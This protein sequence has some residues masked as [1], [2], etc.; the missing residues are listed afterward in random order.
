VIY[1]KSSDFAV[2]LQL[3]PDQEQVLEAY[4]P[5]VELGLVLVIQ[6][7]PLIEIADLVQKM[8]AIPA[9]RLG[10]QLA[11]A[12]TNNVQSLSL[13]TTTV[14][15]VAAAEWIYT[16][17]DATGGIPVN[18]TVSFFIL[19]VGERYVYITFSVPS[20]RYT[21]A[22]PLIDATLHTFTLTGTT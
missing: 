17:T 12:N 3:Q 1:T 16:A 22:K 21:L 2:P 14:N 7:G 13:R 5:T 18:M 15:G 11:V 6:E 4:N 20:T 19:K 9:E 10:E 8:Q